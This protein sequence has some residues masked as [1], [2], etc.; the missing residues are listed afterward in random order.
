[1]GIWHTSFVEKE[2]NMI[3]QFLFGNEF[4]DR[5]NKTY[6]EFPSTIT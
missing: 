6:L 4:K 3:F 1:M 2:S 5:W